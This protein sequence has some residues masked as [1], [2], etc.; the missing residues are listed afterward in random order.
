MLRNRH[1]HVIFLAL[2]LAG[3]APQVS[4][5]AA[6]VVFSVLYNDRKTSPFKS[7]WRILEEY[8][9]RRNV[10]LDVR[11][12][13]DSDYE[14]A[15][16][17]ALESGDIPDIV[18]KV[19][20]KTAESY[21][22]QGILLPV[23]DY[24]DLMPHFMAYIKEHNLQDEVDKLRLNNG[25]YYIF[26]GYQ[27]KMQV[28]QW[29]YR[30]DIFEKH[31]LEA[32]KTY[33]ALYDSLVALKKIYTDSTPITSPWG[34]AHLF[35]MMG[36]AYGIPAGWAGASY[37]DAK[38]DRW[39]FAPATENYRVLYAFL[40]RCYAAGILDPAIFTQSETDAYAKLGD[41]RAFV[42]V[43]WITSGFGPWNA[44]LKE[45]GFPDGEWAP[46]PVPESTIGI[47]ALP[48]VDPFRKGL[49]V[50]SRVTNKPYFNDLLR[51]IDWAVYSEEGTTLTTWGVEGFTY[52]N[53]PNGKGFLPNIKTPKN[54]GGTIEISAEW[55]RHTI[56]PE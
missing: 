17:Q 11:L 55:L 22:N 47:K 19:W 26:P 42:T 3:C 18:L 51:F 41:G 34:G 53:T 1:I 45:N 32:P 29:I 20:P 33:D 46:L 27:R 40:H 16:I 36:A 25:K 13:D 50:S 52:E 28:Q 12:G 6:P 48:P 38:E 7:D 49:I 15:I 39:Q 31:H 43:T 37:Y 56:Q 14:K 9:N 21:A 54:P 23:S 30:R 2:L 10:V 35:A 5:Q 24:E 8:K 4:P 44:K